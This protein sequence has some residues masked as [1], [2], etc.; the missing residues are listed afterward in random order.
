[1]R[2]SWRLGIVLASVVG[3]AGPSAA[4]EK[5]ALTRQQVRA[6]APPGVYLPPIFGAPATPETR[7]L[8][9]AEAGA[10]L[11]RD[12]LFQA[13]GEPLLS[14]T[15]K[16]IGWARE[17]A[18]RLAGATQP[19]DLTAD[20]AELDA[21]EKRLGALAGR[22]SVT[23]P[24]QGGALPSWVWFPE[25][26]PVEDAPAEARFFRCTFTVPAAGVRQAELRIAA[27]D[28]CEAFLN[29]ARIGA[30]D[31]WKEAA[32][33][34]VEK[35]VKPGRNVLAVR[36]ENRPAPTKNPAGLIACLLLTL[37][38]GKPMAV[39]SNAAWR[40]EN[41]ERPGWQQPGLDDSAW[42]A[43]AVVAPF[44]EGPWGRIA[45]LGGDPASAYAD[46]DPAVRDLY[47]AVRRAKRAIAFKNPVVDFSQLLFIDQPYPTGPETRHE[48]IHRMGIW[49]TPGGRL[50]VLD[51]LHPGGSVR[52]LAPEKPGSFWRPDLSF[53]AKRVLFCYKA[54]GEKS[55]HLYEI[56]LDGSGLRQ[57]TTGDY[58]DAD[59]IYL[60]DGHIMFVTTRGNS[61]V[62]CGPFIYSYILA[63]CDADG[64]NVYLIS[65][66]GEPDW[67][68]SLL[69]DGRVIYSRWE[70]TDKP[71]WRVQSL[72]TTNQDGT[73]TTVFWGNQSVWP[74]HLSE[75]MPI[76]G[77]RRVMFSG[78]GHHDWWSGSLGILDPDKGFNFPHGLTKV[79]A[80]L[81]WAECSTPPLDPIESPDYHPS[82][83]FTG[84][85]TAYPL[86]EQDFLVSARRAPGAGDGSGDKFRLYLMDVHGNRDLVYEGVHNVLHAMP[87][88]PRRVPL[89]QPDRVV[90]PG[91]GKDRKPPEPGVFFSADVYQGVPDLPRGSVK[92]LRVWQMDHKTYSTW[93]KTYRHSGPPV[94]IVQEEGVKRIL[95]EVPVEA[96]GSVHFKVPAG[97]ALHF[98]LLDEHR[99]CL[100]TMR[101]FSGVM[102]GEVR[103]CLGC[104]ELHS[105]SP[106][107]RAGTAVSRPP[108]ELS[109]PP[110][111][112]ESIGYE[113][114][115]QP[116]LDRYCGKCHQGE[117]K[118]RQKLDLTL[119]PGVSV[120]KEP[121]LTLVGSAGWGNPVGNKGQPGYGIA[122][123]IPVETID[124]STND[125]R[126][127][128]TFRPMAYLS[129][130][131]KLIEYAMSG[132]HNDV[133]VD[134]LSL[135]RL[136]AWVDAC[137]P[138]MGDP[139]VRALGDPD[140]PGIDEL[141]IRPRVQ[142]APVIERP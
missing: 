123:P 12:W 66:G 34:A 131:S 32:A 1:M 61:Y 40:A 28:A 68:P 92:Y 52:K 128:A 5:P 85:K 20:L 16:E 70:Y 72:W 39:V 122:A 129:Y 111:G 133:K 77:S 62:R 76:P 137:S 136:I 119:R 25:G 88:K 78:V 115:V 138:Y 141:P 31:T 75:P 3:A 14:R 82:G 97:R 35:Q 46:M 109:P 4:A 107:P 54:H 37:A 108:T 9:P 127:Y 91:T 23:A 101:S 114:F 124:P 60:P 84:Y 106:A 36:A 29:G 50:M 89:K 41:A 59:P 116:V 17:L 83:R 63:R 15:A 69:N 58:D 93:R 10:V 71:L 22:G 98:Q 120:F 135:H 49:A 8:T 56:G 103:G 104:H 126:A 64:A 26:R 79:T 51:G 100:Q 81:R 112:T 11:E 53:D 105:A 24:A 99:R 6:M 132:K 73:N 95:S 96:D 2:A 33:F 90:W 102:P 125:P 27:D 18:R 94:S 44:G 21:L 48:A 110:W 142:T 113:R 47:L 118:G 74:D 57:L 65:M 55:F 140:F 30:N 80:D 45:G 42:K 121:Y 86:S 43:A 19:P 7:T 134:P 13:M 87:V 117:G 130:R 67:T 38:D 139:E